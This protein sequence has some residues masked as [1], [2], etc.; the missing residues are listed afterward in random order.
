M[1]S[2][3]RLR[4]PIGISDFRELRELGVLYVDKTDFVT[5]VLA[6]FSKVVLV[7]RPRRFGKTVNLS[8]VRYFV[9]KSK[10]DRSSLFEGLS[11]WS[12]PEARKHFQ[13]YP[14]IALTFKD[15]KA[16]AFD[17]AFVQIKKE[18]AKAYREHSYLLREGSLEPWEAAQFE[19]IVRADGPASIYGSALL[20]LSA[21]LAR[22][23][24]EK[25][26][27]LID[28]YDTPIH[29]A[30][31]GRNER[32]ILDFFRMFLS[33]ALKDNT[34][35]EKGVLTGILRVAKESLFSGLNN[36][37]VYS[38]IRSECA[39]CFGFTEAE[40]KDLA[41]RTGAETSIAEIERWYNGYRFG[42]QVIY[43]PWSVL[44][45][46]ASED[47]VLRPY[48]VHTSSDDL[49]R[50]VI[51]SHGLGQDGELE[52]LLGGG[53]IEKRIDD[54]VALRDLDTTPEAV[55]SFLLFTG[56][57][58]ATTVRMEGAETRATLAIPN[59]E[60][61]YVYRTLFQG[62]LEQ[63]LGGERQ[64]DVLLQAIL[65]GDAEGCERS[66]EV[67]LHSLSLHDVA[68]R[69]TGADRD[70][71]IDA[72]LNTDV[73][74]TEMTPEQLYHVFVVGLLVGLQPRFAV[75]SNRES[76]HGRCDVLILPVTPG[77]PGV[78]LELKVP[79]QRRRETPKAAMTAALT[80]LRERDYAAEL[81]ACGAAPIHE[82]GIVF[83]GKRARVEVARPASREPTT[84]R[85]VT[86]KPVTR[87]PVTKKPVAKKP[88]TKKPVAKKPLTKKPVA[89]RP[90]TRKPVTKKPVAKKPL[91]R[92]PVTKK[93][94]AKKTA[95][96]KLASRR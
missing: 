85:A 27:I 62:W 34:H 14:V 66:L 87:K 17:V 81:R 69:R 6:A 5:Q 40:V 8:T 58:K 90:L 61:E 41:T 3:A 32:A 7:P 12:S 35:L 45:F 86:K 9:E 57:L 96:K 59:K 2:A 26:I 95:A 78:A 79:N 23:H 39:T 91:T 82:M 93:P 92:K 83:Q 28:E 20:D 60:V 13:R 50:R 25:V 16:A 30:A 94:A 47:K 4:L 72:E 10:E 1:V 24:G 65:A 31:S 70:E 49:L 67:L 19:Q 18:I 74:L 53:E 46:L 36:L 68:V 73:A 38:L 48:W 64:V 22:Y 43:N 15:I 89:K 63:R 56:Y 75:R 55:W 77:Q 76:G 11:V 51:F 54:R 71:R 33:S 42:G 44:N 21:L 88:L 29:A 37:V 80:Q 52:I 84:T